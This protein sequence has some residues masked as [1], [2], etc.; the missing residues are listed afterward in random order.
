LAPRR[1]TQEEH[2]YLDRMSL[3]LISPVQAPLAVAQGLVCYPTLA[4]HQAPLA[5][6][7]QAQVEFCYLDRMK[8]AQISPLQAPSAVAKGPVNPPFPTSPESVPP[9]PSLTA[10]VSSLSVRTLILAVGEPSHSVK[11]LSPRILSR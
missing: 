4:P 11:L 6:T 2:W 10:A 7:R 5:P 1:L 8:L 9:I 3:A